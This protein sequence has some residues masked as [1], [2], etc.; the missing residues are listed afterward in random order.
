MVNVSQKKFK[1]LNEQFEKT[2]EDLEDLELYT[3]DLISFVPVA[4]CLLSGVKKIVNSNKA[5]ESLIGY[6]L[7]E[8]SGTFLEKL[9]LE[10]KKIRDLLNE[11]S[12]KETIKNKEFTLISKEKKEIPVSLSIS[13]RRDK[14]ENLIGYFI[15]ILDITELKELQESLEKKVKER[16]K[17]LQERIDELER[18]QKLTEGR[19]LRMIELKEEIE[20]LKERVKANKI[21]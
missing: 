3:Q 4:F 16:T 10:K 19:E 17:E 8:I 14:E 21:E 6:D 11:A 12:K 13:T 18:F 2:R 1:E 9:F 15:G 5:F 20:R 7:M